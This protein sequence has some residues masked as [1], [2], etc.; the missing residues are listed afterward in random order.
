MFQNDNEKGWVGFQNQTFRRN[1]NILG[2]WGFDI[3][4]L[5]YTWFCF[6]TKVP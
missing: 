6:I 5:M 2:F 4:K 1:V 3:Y